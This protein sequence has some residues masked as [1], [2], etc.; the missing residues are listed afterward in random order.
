M[1]ENPFNSRIQYRLKQDKDS[2][3][4]REWYNRLQQPVFQRYHDQKVLREDIACG[5]S[6]FYPLVERLSRLPVH[7]YCVCFPGRAERIGE[8]VCEDRVQAL[9]AIR[10]EVL[11]VLSLFNSA[12]SAVRTILLGHGMGAILAYDLC[13]ILASDKIAIE[14]LVVCSSPSPLVLSR[15][16]RPRENF[17]PSD[18][19]SSTTSAANP[20]RSRREILRDYLNIYGGIVEDSDL[21][22]RKDLLNLF[23]PA[24]QADERLLD[25]YVPLPP[26][27]PTADLESQLIEGFSMQ[28]SLDTLRE[29]GVGVYKVQA[30]I[31]Y[32]HG[33]ESAPTTEEKEQEEKT[34]SS[35]P[36]TA[37]SSRTSSNRQMLSSR[38]STGLS[39]LLSSA[40]R[41]NNATVVQE[42][43]GWEELTR[44]GYEEQVFVVGGHFC[45]VHPDACDYLCDIVRQLSGDGDNGQTKGTTDYGDN[46][47]DD[48]K[49]S[50]R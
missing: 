41:G 15:A 10:R 8:K 34:A 20:V 35:Y 7:F 28:E 36:S 46:S 49:T 14:R 5:P 12:S 29:M 3:E 50:G 31:I 17:D 25:N 2:I 47:S 32:I 26:L 42:D 44:S 16:I 38:Q 33:L 9:V 27:L 23:V 11:K 40:L 22:V 21:L 13:R 39:S 4:R 37:L 45:I 1:A 6:L 24:I 48:G 18:R 30:S 19:S 43:E